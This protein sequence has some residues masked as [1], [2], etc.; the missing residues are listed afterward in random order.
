MNRVTPLALMIAGLLGTAPAM[1]ADEELRQEIEN[2]KQENRTI[3]ERLNATSEMIENNRSAGAASPVSIGGYG[4]LHYNNLSNNLAGGSDKDMLD[5]HRF[6]L[7]FGYEYTDDIRFFSELE[8]EH[9]YAADSA[10]GSKPGAVELEQAYVEF[11]LNDKTSAKGGVFL[12]P[13]GIL[14]ETHEPPT[15]YGV[16]RNPVE[17]NIIPTTWWAAGA[18]LTGR[19]GQGFSYNLGIH[20][21]LKLDPSGDMA[22]RSGRQKS[23]EADASDLA[24][25]ARLKYTGI[26]GLELAATVQH[27]TDISQAPG[28]NLGSANLIEAHAIYTSGAFGL[29]ALYATW[30]LDGTAPAANGADEQTGWFIEPSYKLTS[31]FGVFARH[32]VWDNQAGS[33]ADTEYSQTDVGFNYWPHEDVVIKMDY[34]TQDAPAGENEYDGFNVGIGYQF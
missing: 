8:I 31:K 7:F 3:M 26:P 24:S 27:Q 25:T 28:D 32:N 14:N 15:F 12:L 1:A 22:V 18:E 5:F 23:A 6:V 9:A 20:E 16:E 13:V 33:S 2:L 21:G 4:E 17:K 30:D 19:F 29:R 10:D 34:Q 11:D